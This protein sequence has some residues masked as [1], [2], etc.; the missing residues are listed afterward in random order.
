MQVL[1]YFMNPMPSI[2]L[3]SICILQL[4]VTQIVAGKIYDW[5]KRGV[6]S[7]NCAA[8]SSSKLFISAKVISIIRRRNKLVYNKWLKLTF[9]CMQMCSWHARDHW[10]KRASSWDCCSKWPRLFFINPNYL[11]SQWLWS[12]QNNVS[13]ETLNHRPYRF[14]NY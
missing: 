11:M 2:K 1:Q 9:I 7:C 8:D 13:R 10:R 5:Q 4:N 3:K 14:S 12:M 6:Q